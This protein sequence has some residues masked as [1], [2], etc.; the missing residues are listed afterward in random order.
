MTEITPFNYNNTE[1]RVITDE[2][3]THWW[4]A[5]DVCD[6]LGLGNVT[7]SLAKIPGGTQGG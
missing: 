5:K 4:V 1:L 7:N 6:I 3:G 2:N